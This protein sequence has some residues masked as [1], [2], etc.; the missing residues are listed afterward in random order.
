MRMTMYHWRNNLFIIRAFRRIVHQAHES[1]NLKQAM[2]ISTPNKKFPI[3]LYQAI[4]RDFLPSIQQPVMKIFSVLFLILFFMMMITKL[5]HCTFFISHHPPA[6]V[7]N[8]MFIFFC[9]S[10]MSQYNPKIQHNAG[11][12]TTTSRRLDR[13]NQPEHILEV[14]K[15]LAKRWCEI[16]YTNRAKCVIWCSQI[17]NQNLM[18]V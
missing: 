7:I 16:N 10:L 18:C 13:E 8:I 2:T 11:L 12:I 4:R 9:L 14:R 17:L 5:C 3:N 15:P 6:R 1:L